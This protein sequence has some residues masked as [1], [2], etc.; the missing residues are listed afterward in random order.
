[1]FFFLVLGNCYNTS[2]SRIEHS[3]QVTINETVNEDLYITAGT[4][5]VN[6]PVHGDLTVAGGTVVINDTVTGD[7]IVIGGSL[8]FNG[9]AED[10]IR[11]AGGKI[12]IHKHVAGDVVAAGGNVHIY[13]D[14]V[15]GGMMVTGGNIVIDGNV[16]GNTRLTAGYIVLNGSFGGNLYCRGEDIIINGTVTGMTILAADNITIGNT[17]LFY[18]DVHYWS[19]AGEIDFNKRLVNSRAVYDPSL[20]VQTARWYFLGASTLLGLLWYLGMAMLMIFIVQ[21]FFAGIMK[22]AA[23]TAAGHSFRSFAFGLLFFV[24][25]PVAAAA[26]IITLVGVPVGLLLLAG[27]FILIA[28]ATVITSVVAANWFAAANKYDYSKAKLAWI[29]CIF[30]ILFKLLASATFFGQ[31]LALVFV[32]IAFGGIVQ[33]I[34]WRKKDNLAK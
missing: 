15:V 26:A 10:D 25:V 32:C 13:K 8:T 21:Y 20:R 1:M 30:F 9:F 31:F 16:N 5:T 19:R 29:S 28:L 11:C 6:A 34:H 18:N 33:L 7:V 12:F 22:K 23:M 24:A 17:A 27:Y 14:A 3:D 4:V 2:A